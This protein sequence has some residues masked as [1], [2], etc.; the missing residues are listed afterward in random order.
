MDNSFELNLKIPADQVAGPIRRP[1]Q[2][3]RRQARAAYCGAGDQAL[4][5]QSIRA[6]VEHAFEQMPASCGAV[7]Q[8]QHSMDVKTGFAVVAQRDVINRDQHLAL[9]TDWNFPAS[10]GV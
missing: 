4:P 1:S 10:L 6:L 7:A 2:S 9:F 3:K 5:P 8:S